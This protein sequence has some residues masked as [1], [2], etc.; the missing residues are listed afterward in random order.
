MPTKKSRPS[1]LVKSATSTSIRVVVY[2]QLKP[3]RQR[4]LILIICDRLKL[5]LLFSQVVAVGSDMPNLYLTVLALIILTSTSLSAQAN[6]SNNG[7]NHNIARNGHLAHRDLGSGSLAL[8]PLKKTIV[9]TPYG[10]I[11]VDKGAF[12]IIVVSADVLSAYNLIAGH[13]IRLTANDVKVDILPGNCAVLATFDAK[14]FAEINKAQFIPY[15]HVTSDS[16]GKEGKLFTA[17]FDVMAMVRGLPLV[18]AQVEENGWK[19]DLE[20]QAAHRLISSGEYFHLFISAKEREKYS[21][22]IVNEAV[23]KN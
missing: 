9:D 10:A 15:R 16:I 8:S 13:K 17:E 20:K 19:N 5:L 6:E 2:T 4:P 12:A 21:L 18:Q 22:P 1:N 23:Q 14:S 3:K 11:T 7:D